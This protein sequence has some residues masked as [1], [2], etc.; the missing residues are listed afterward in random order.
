MKIFERF[1]DS[2][3]SVKKT[4]TNV[5][6]MDNLQTCAANTSTIRTPVEARKA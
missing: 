3:Y 2:L 6:I 5:L 4:Q 1:L